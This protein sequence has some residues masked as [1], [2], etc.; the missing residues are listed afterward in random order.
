MPKPTRAF[1]KTDTRGQKPWLKSKEVK[2]YN[3]ESREVKKRFLIVCEGQTEELYFK[4]FPV[5]TANV[6]AEPSGRSNSSLVEYTRILS[7]DEDYDEIWCVFD[8]DHKGTVKGQ[9]E[10]FDKAITL[11]IKNK[12]KCAYSNDAFE[13]WF[14]L[15]FQNI[16]QKQLRTFYYK[17][18]SEY[19]EI[20][21]E[22]NGKAKAFAKT[23]YSI[24]SKDNRANQDLAIRYAKALFKKHKAKEYHKHNPV[25]IVYE[26][27]E[28]LNKHLKK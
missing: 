9:K 24:L 14:V 12:F 3:P 5:Q 7:E 16:D 1:K 8:F 17:K 13:L 25:T 19:W 18:L 2:G 28:E 26:L 21:Y 6:K 20:N 27:V 11:A 15:H 10:D 22:K 4:S 23:I